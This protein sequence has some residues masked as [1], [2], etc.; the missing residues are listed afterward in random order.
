[1]VDE[2]SSNRV[3]VRYNEEKLLDVVAVRRAEM[4]EHQLEGA[5]KCGMSRTKKAEAKLSNPKLK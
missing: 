4:I 1:M 3:T 2:L 5:M